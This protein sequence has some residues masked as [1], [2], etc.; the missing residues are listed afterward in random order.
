M[1]SDTVRKRWARKGGGVRCRRQAE[2]LL[3]SD[4]KGIGIFVTV[5]PLERLDEESAGICHLIHSVRVFAGVCN[6]KCIM[7][8]SNFRALDDFMA[9]LF[10]EISR[11]VTPLA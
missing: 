2:N 8:N 11:L 10:S 6:V 4:V 7:G 1:Y 5:A 3:A 9:P